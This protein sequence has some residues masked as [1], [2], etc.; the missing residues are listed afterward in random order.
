MPTRSLLLIGAL[1][2]PAAARAQSTELA[3]G[4]FVYATPAGNVVTF[5]GADGAFVVGP[6]TNASTPAIQ[7]D[8]SRR[9]SVAERFVIVIPTDQTRADGDAGWGRLGAFVATH[10]NGW[11]HF[12]NGT[13]PRAA[14]SEVLKFLVGNESIHAVHQP[15]AHSNGDVLVHFERS[16]VVYLGELLP[17]DG[18]P[19]IQAANGG[20]IDSFVVLLHPWASNP[21]KFV[22]ARG[23]VLTDRYVAS[24][25]NALTTTRDRVKQMKDAGQSVDQVI[26]ARPT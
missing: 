10:E 22:P 21:N 17:G 18:Y 9:T 7:A 16:G 14:F 12:P 20:G 2:A 26:A 25:L 24:Y 23:A 6:V 1:L 8:L 13:R 19:D 3:P 11:S 15:P 4:L 5:A